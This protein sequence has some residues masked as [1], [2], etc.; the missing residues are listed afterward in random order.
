MENKKSKSAMACSK[1]RYVFDK[2]NYRAAGCSALPHLLLQ[3]IELGRIE[4]FSKCDIQSVANH[5][6]GDNFRVKAF[7]VKDILDG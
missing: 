4:E 7:A 5:F 3:T 2:S 6:D 1:L